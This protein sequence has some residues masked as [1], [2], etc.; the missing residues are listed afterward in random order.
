MLRRIRLPTMLLLKIIEWLGEP[1]RLRRV[2]HSRRPY[3]DPPRSRGCLTF[4]LESSASP[5]A[6]FF[7]FII[8][9]EAGGLRRGGRFFD[10]GL[11]SVLNW[12]QPRIGHLQKF[13][14]Q[15][16]VRGFRCVRA[17]L[18][19]LTLTKSEQVVFHVSQPVMRPILANSQSI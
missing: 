7:I 1:F 15:R 18:R 17:Q 5:E 10:L 2:L 14:F 13:L 12:R 8:R 3:P 16:R 4:E 19:G 6:G 9:A 11:R